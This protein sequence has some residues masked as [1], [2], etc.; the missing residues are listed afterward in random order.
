VSNIGT[1]AFA[2][3]TLLRN[4]F[5]ST[6]T[7]A[8]L[9]RQIVPIQTWISPSQSPHILSPYFYGAPYTVRFFAP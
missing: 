2:N 8:N 7:A 5:I 3:C 4:V 6:T 9:G 1:N